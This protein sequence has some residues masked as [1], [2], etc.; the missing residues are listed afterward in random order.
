LL[1]FEIFPERNSKSNLQ[2]R[3]CVYNGTLW[4]VGSTTAEVEKQYLLHIYAE[5]DFVALGIQRA[6]R[7]LHIAICG[8][9]G[10]EYFSTLSHLGHDFRKKMFM[11]NKMF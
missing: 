8:V 3:Q 11:E 10:S 9:C 2:D 5:C 7:L 6:M 4:R 1:L